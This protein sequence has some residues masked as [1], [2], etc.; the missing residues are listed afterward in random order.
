MRSG[1]VTKICPPFPL[2][3][4]VE[5]LRDIGHSMTIENL[6]VSVNSV[7]VSYLIHMTVYYTMRHILLQNVTAILY[8]KMRQ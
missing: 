7:T 6:I 8:H 2:L 3:S 1:R 5:E 4:K